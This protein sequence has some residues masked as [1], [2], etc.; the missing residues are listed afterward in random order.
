MNQPIQ[1]D[2]PLNNIVKKPESQSDS[3]PSIFLLHGFGSNMQDL[4]GITPFF[5][6]HW[7]CISLQAT[8][9]VQYNG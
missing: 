8:I 6:K 9:P 7:T 5:E 4:F 1:L 3:S 2:L